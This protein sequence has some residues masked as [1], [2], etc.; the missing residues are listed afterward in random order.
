MPARCMSS[1]SFKLPDLPYD[2]N[3]LEPVISADIMKLHHQKHHNTYVINLN[4]A[5]E[6]LEDAKVGRLPPSAVCICCASMT[7]KA[8][9]AKRDVNAIVQLEPV[10][11]FNGGGHVNHSIFWQNLAPKGKGGG[12]GMAGD[13][14]DMV[15]NQW[16]SPEKM[17][18]ALGNAAIAVQGSGWAWLGFCK[19]TG[20]LRIATCA[21]QD[22]LQG[23]Q[24]L[25]PLFGIDVWEHAYYLQVP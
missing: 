5:M 21:N 14:L 20:I 22:P 19:T 6:K 3:A 9:Q 23:T 2:Y 11:R 13:L 12:E 1:V 7:F 24:G 25:V 10:I 16:G 17:Q 18:E 8:C 4:A 15:R